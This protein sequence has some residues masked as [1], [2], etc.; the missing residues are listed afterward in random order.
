M[1]EDRKRAAGFI[2]TAFGLATGRIREDLGE[3]GAAANG[4]LALS[5]GADLI[6]EGLINAPSDDFSD[7]ADFKALIDFEFED[8][9]HLVKRLKHMPDE[10][11]E[12]LAYCAEAF[13]TDLVKGDAIPME[14]S[15][16]TKL[17]RMMA[18]SSERKP[19]SPRR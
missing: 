19:K 5:V 4:I 11:V 6:A 16:K 12:R 8:E 9:D 13:F 18:S 7:R 14:A 3:R 17:I 1:S 2:K 10:E 15:E